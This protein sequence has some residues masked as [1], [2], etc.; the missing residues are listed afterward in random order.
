[1]KDLLEEIL[2]IAKH[3]CYDKGPRFIQSHSQNASL[4]F[5]SLTSMGTFT[6]DIIR[7]GY[8]IFWFEKLIYLNLRMIAWKNS[9]SQ[10]TPHPTPTSASS[11]CETQHIYSTP[12]PLQFLKCSYIYLRYISTHRSLSSGIALRD[13]LVL[14]EKPRVLNMAINFLIINLIN[15]H[16][17]PHVF[18]SWMRDIF[19]GLKYLSFIYP[20]T[21]RSNHYS[22]I[23]V[24]IQATTK[25]GEEFVMSIER[26]EE[27]GM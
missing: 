3:R 14:T 13:N 25:N 26:K 21:V 9:S 19:I 16:L 5:V 7:Q 8:I 18:L 23:H 2:F 6:V 24:P 1:M 12:P 4:L 15:F 17:H 27:K 10:I 20:F 22:E 11:H